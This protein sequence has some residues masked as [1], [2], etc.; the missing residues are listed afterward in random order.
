MAV[1]SFGNI[2]YTVPGGGMTLLSTT[3]L[4]GTTTTISSINQTYNDL[5]VVVKGYTFSAAANL[6]INPVSSASSCPGVGV[7]NAGAAFSPNNLE[8]GTT[9][10][11][12][13]ANAN[14]FYLYISQYADSTN[15]KAYQMYSWNSSTPRIV[16]G[17]V[18]FATAITSIAVT[19][20]AGTSS[21][22]AG[23][24]LIYGVK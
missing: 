12:P 3:S 22:T 5:I 7:S 17:A 21:F 8:D 1:N 18:N 16:A 20:A 9:T 19:T 15:R 23:Q 14:V 6:R 24:V 11:A 4:S 10:V 13:G 2:D